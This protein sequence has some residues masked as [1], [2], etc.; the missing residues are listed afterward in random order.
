MIAVPRSTL[1]AQ[2]CF[3]LRDVKGLIQVSVFYWN[4][5]ARTL[6]LMAW[7][8]WLTCTKSI[9]PLCSHLE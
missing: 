9:N 6:F 7:G 5:S 4:S 3:I 8:A 2:S 1:P